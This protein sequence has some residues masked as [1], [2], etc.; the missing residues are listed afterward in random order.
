[1]A[2][3]VPGASSPSALWN[4]IE[5]Q[6]D[7]QRKMPENRFNVDSF[8]H[9]DGKNKGTTV[10]TNARYGYFLDQDLGAFDPGFFNISGKRG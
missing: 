8:Y 10:Q 4:L 6:K 9:P 1:M 5:Q 2:C 3:R 7:V